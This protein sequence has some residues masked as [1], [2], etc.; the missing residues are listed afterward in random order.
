MSNRGC[1]GRAWAEIS[2]P[3]APNP[4]HC[5]DQTIEFGANGQRDRVHQRYPHLPHQGMCP[6]VSL[7][8]Q[9]G[10]RWSTVWPRI[11]SD[12]DSKETKDPQPTSQH[13]T[14]LDPI[15]SRWRR[16]SNICTRNE[17]QYLCTETVRGKGQSVP[18]ILVRICESQ[19]DK[20]NVSPWL[21][22]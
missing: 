2:R 22:T 1:I 10:R 12:V 21:C 11:L 8:R 14:D 3:R 7:L 16:N 17:W 13:R 6:D 19:C 9:R 5:D 15:S 18:Q 4:R 20:G